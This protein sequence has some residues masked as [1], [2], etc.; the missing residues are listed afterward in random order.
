MLRPGKIL[1]G[2]E[3]VEK[4][5]PAFKDCLVHA[6]RCLYSYVGH[7]IA[8]HM[9]HVGL[10]DPGWL[11]ELPEHLMVHAKLCNLKVP[12]FVVARHCARLLATLS[13]RNDSK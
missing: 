13:D 11:Y 7:V 1:C 2:E 3:M 4:A 6:Q 9:D 5:C 10:K 8:L 12:A